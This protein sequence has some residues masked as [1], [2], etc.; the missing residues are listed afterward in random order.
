MN[1]EPASR[2][3]NAAVLPDRSPGAMD[4]ISKVPDEEERKRLAK[5]PGD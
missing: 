2:I 5:H 4:T 3:V 1:E